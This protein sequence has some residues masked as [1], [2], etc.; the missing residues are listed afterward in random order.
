MSTK[1]A[2]KPNLVTV[3]LAWTSGGVCEM[4]DLC[5]FPYFSPNLG[6]KPLTRAATIIKIIYYY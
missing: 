5:D 3:G 4:Y 2:L 6:T 1:Y